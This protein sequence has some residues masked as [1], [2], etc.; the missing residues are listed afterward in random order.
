MHTEALTTKRGKEGNLVQK[1]KRCA[2]P[3][4]RERANARFAFPRRFAATSKQQH[5]NKFNFNAS[6]DSHLASADSHL[7]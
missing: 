1:S 5:C 7:P 2:L 3:I 4:R 6:G